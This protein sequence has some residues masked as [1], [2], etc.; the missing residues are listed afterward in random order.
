M[1]YFCEPT[2]LNGILRYLIKAAQDKR[3]VT[4]QEIENIFGLSHNIMA[5]YA[6]EVGYFCQ[7][8]ELPLLNSL[9]I[10]STFCRPSEG[11]DSFPEDN[12]TWEDHLIHCFQFYHITTSREMQT[13]NFKGLN[14]L[15]REFSKNRN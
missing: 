5:F 8:H 10:S 11:W 7:D 1:K 12:T 15:C 13:R 14:H 3:L 4:Y 6:G 2:V 9:L